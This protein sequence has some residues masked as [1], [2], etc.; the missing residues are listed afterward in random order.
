MHPI[1]PGPGFL[2]LGGMSIVAGRVVIR[3]VPLR[4]S[5]ACPRCGR[6]SGRVHS[7]YWRRGGDVPFSG[8]RVEVVIGARKFFCDNGSC[9]RAIF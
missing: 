9:P 5:A 1:N 8:N 2:R 6:D 4:K 3:F 7:R